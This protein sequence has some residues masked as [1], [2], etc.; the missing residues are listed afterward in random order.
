MKALP[1]TPKPRAKAAAFRLLTSSF[2]KRE[3]LPFA[4]LLLPFQSRFRGKSQV[5]WSA[6]IYAVLLREPQAF[7]QFLL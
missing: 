7:T 6:A 4:F 2:P 1:A 5:A 3:L